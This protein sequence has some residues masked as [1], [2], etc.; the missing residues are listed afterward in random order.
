MLRYIKKLRDIYLVK[1]KWRKYLIKEGFHAG[2]GVAFWC[3]NNLSIGKNF[4]IGRFSQIECD[5]EIGDNVIFAN[6]V[7]LVGRYD[8]NYK[9]IGVPIRL[10]SKIMDV[11]YDWKGINSKVIIEDDVWVGYG[12]ILVSGIKIGRGSI[13]AAGS[14]VTKDI[15]PYTIVG[16]NPAKFIKY[17]FTEDEII[18]HEKKIY[19]NK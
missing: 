11:D 1:V 6:Y 16:G 12:S 14:I 5:A 17:R 9:Q 8:H 10:A 3:K 4:Y 13:I 19:L 18:E 15:E 2:R 7:A